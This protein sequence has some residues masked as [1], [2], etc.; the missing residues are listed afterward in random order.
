MLLKYLNKGLGLFGYRF[1]NLKRREL[2]KDFEEEFLRIYE[3]CAPYT[4]TSPERMY[5]TYLSTRYVIENNIDGDFIECGVWKGGSVLV[6][7]HTLIVKGFTNRHIFLYDTFE[8]MIEPTE[9]DIDLYGKSAINKWK[10]HLREDKNLWCYASLEEVK[11]NIGT[12]GY[13]QDKIHFIK[14]KVEETIPNAV[15]HE[16]IAI[17]R[18]DTDWYASSYHELK[19]LYPKLVK[20]GVLLLDDYGF[21]EG[22]KKATDQYFS[23]N[24]IKPFLIRVDYSG[25]M[26]LKM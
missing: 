22:Q 20:G 15:N 21:W 11:N 3:K 14:G 12:A 5:A 6:M 8:G 17:L 13:P 18:L 19:H 1:I 26:V 10:R 9:A 2:P 25:R 24:N 7:I 16:R 23:E 4:M